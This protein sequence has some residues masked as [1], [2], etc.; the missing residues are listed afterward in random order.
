M[1]LDQRDQVEDSV[2]VELI[3]DGLGLPSWARERITGWS[4]ATAGV[5]A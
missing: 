3:S 2:S 1:S 4:Y 5:S